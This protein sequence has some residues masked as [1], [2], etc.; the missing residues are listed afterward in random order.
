MIAILVGILTRNPS[1]FSFLRCSVTVPEGLLVERSV[2]GAGSLGAAPV[3][4]APEAPAVL[5]VRVRDLKVRV[6][7]TDLHRMSYGD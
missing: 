2:D 1:V 4:A 5:G 3:E 7:D 6:G